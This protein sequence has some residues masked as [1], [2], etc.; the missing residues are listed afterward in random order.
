MPA[1]G[2][3]LQLPF[4]FIHALDGRLQGDSVVLAPKRRRLAGHNQSTPNK[5]RGVRR[6]GPTLVDQLL[7]QGVKRVQGPGQFR[8]RVK[9]TDA[10]TQLANRIARGL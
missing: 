3:P 9:G 1:R 6:S 4:S 10:L 8:D 2:P 5:R 7:P